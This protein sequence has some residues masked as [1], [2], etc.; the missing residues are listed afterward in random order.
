[1]QRKLIW[2]ILT[3]SFLI[4]I[5]TN[6]LASKYEASDVLGYWLSEEKD[7]VIHLK[8]E[9]NDYKG[10]LVWIKELAEGVKKEILDMENPDEKLR[11]RSLQGIRLL[12]GFKFDGDKWVGGSI[13]DPKSGKT[14]KAKMTLKDKNTLELRGYVGIPLFGRTSVWTRHENPVSH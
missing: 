9:D 7:G 3:L 12:E 6:A 14:Y 5:T 8:M 1:M 2:P 13:Y 10:Y 11:A 4:S